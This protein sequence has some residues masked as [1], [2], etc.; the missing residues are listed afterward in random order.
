MQPQIEGRTQSRRSQKSDHAVETVALAENENRPRQ[1]GIVQVLA[2]ENRQQN[3]DRDEADAEGRQNAV[4]LEL[5]L[6]LGASDE[7]IDENSIDRP[8]QDKGR[9]RDQ[10]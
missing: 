10:E 1:I 5:A 4:D 6:A 9:R 8:V 3:T 7:R 2:A